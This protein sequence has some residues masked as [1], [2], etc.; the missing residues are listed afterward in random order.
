ME[1]E[2]DISED[3][4]ITIDDSLLQLSLDCEPKDEEE[5]EEEEAAPHPVSS[6]SYVEE[7]KS[8]SDLKVLHE[9]NTIIVFAWYIEVGLIHLFL[10]KSWFKSMLQWTN[11]SLQWK[12]KKV[13]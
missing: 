11:K 5:T 3:L 12:G 1:A 9:C 2:E 8:K 10:S 6:V 4:E 13:Y 7:L